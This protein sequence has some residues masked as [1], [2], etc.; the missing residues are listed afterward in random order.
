MYIETKANVGYNAVRIEPPRTKEA[1]NAG[2]PN[3]QFTR[4]NHVR[5]AHGPADAFGPKVG[6]AKV[7]HLTG[8][9]SAQ[10]FVTP[11]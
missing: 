3:L 1:Q 7:R 4:G 10:L 11:H 2:Q 9:R 8:K 6:R 5:P